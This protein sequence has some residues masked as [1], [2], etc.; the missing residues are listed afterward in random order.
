M[1]F[2]EKNICDKDAYA[3][4]KQHMWYLY[5]D[6]W[7]HLF[8]KDG[9]RYTEIPKPF[10]HKVQEEIRKDWNAYYEKK[11]AHEKKMFEKE[12][13]EAAEDEEKAQTLSY[14]EYREWKYNKEQEDEDTWLD[15]VCERIETEW[16][17]ERRV[18]NGLIW[19]EE[20]IQDGNIIIGNDGSYIYNA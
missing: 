12:A 6:K 15:S 7:F 8:D 9:S 1:Q 14:E 19:L 18:K 5:G 17:Q 11:E 13:I 16:E 10:Y 3:L 20:Q 2:E 4:Y